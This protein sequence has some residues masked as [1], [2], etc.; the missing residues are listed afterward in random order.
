MKK[1]GSLKVLISRGLVKLSA[2]MPHYA[3]ENL[4]RSKTTHAESGTR[5]RVKQEM[6][7]QDM[8]RAV[9]GR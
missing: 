1:P 9:E 5:V 6:D 3:L 4:K 2:A 8:T 7:C